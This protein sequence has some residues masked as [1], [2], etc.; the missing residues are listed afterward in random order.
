VLLVARPSVDEADSRA[1]GLGRHWARQDVRLLE[2][3]VGLP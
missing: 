1:C 2:H 3:K